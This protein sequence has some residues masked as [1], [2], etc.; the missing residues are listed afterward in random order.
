[1]LAPRSYQPRVLEVAMSSNDGSDAGDAPNKV[2]EQL[3][4]APATRVLEGTAC[5]VPPQTAIR[6]MV[7]DAKRAGAAVG[8]EAIAAMFGEMLDEMMEDAGRSAAT[9]APASQ[10][11]YEP[12]VFSAFDAMEAVLPLGTIAV[13][14]THAGLGHASWA[15]R[16]YHTRQLAEQV[17]SVHGEARGLRLKEFTWWVLE[18]EYGPLVHLLNQ[19]ER[20]R[21]GQRYEAFDTVGRAVRAARTSGVLGAVLWEDA[22]RVRNAA[23]HHGGWRVDIDRNVVVLRN[24]SPNG[25]V[26][27]AEFTIDALGETIAALLGLTGVMMAAFQRAVHRDFL[28]SFGPAFSAWARTKDEAAFETDAKPAL[29]TMERTWTAL[30]NLGWP[31]APTS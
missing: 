26:W 27:T 2:L 8:P 24:S 25:P 4:I 16:N 6:T 14:F 20:A 7:D 12:Q 17:L 23:A 10:L 19:L 1:M 31:P 11:V 29:E 18:Y 9:S 21:Q 28:P 13:L 15:E 3:M 30:Q 5:G 22:G